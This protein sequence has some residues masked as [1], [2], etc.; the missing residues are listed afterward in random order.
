MIKNDFL[1]PKSEEKE[2]NKE[3]IINN[4]NDI[5]IEIIPE[6][7]FSGIKKVKKVKEI[8]RILNSF[9]D[10]NL[11]E[12]PLKTDILCWWCCHSFETEPVPCIIGYD[13]IKQKYKAKG[14]FCSWEC[15]CA[16]SIDTY[17]SLSYMYL[18]RQM[19][20]DEV[21]DDLKVAPNK[22]VL[23]SFGGHL[24]ID[25]FRNFHEKNNHEI[26][27]STDYL[28]YVNQDILELYNI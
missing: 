19:L 22:I 1:I 27:I 17:K 23:K 18:Y 26:K 6:K 9:S 20:T 7:K 28:S 3:L 11:K 10:D 15:A 8:F 4:N 12:W 14:I 13:K 16:Y 5:D 21:C 2:E 25:E 24:T